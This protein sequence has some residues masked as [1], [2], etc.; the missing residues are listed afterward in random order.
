MNANGCKKRITNATCEI[1]MNAY[2]NKKWQNSQSP[3]G[4]CLMFVAVGAQGRKKKQTSGRNVQAR[5]E[6]D[7][8]D[9][10]WNKKIYM[11]ALK[12]NGTHCVPSRRC[13]MKTCIVFKNTEKYTEASMHNDI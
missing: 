13:E 12:G 7:S 5:R 6:Y 3:R 10:F 4:M 1:F 9:V 11:E 2:Q 8:A